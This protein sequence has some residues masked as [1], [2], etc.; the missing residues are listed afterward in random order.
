MRVYT[1]RMNPPY[2]M[3]GQ[4]V[5]KIIESKDPEYPKDSVVLT[6]SGWVKTGIVQTSGSL[7]GFGIKANQ[8]V[9][10]VPDLPPGLSQSVLLGVCGMPGCTAYFGF[11]EICQPKSGET[12]VVNGA[13][14]AVG[15]LVGQIAK[16]KGCHVIGFAGSDDKCQTLLKKYGFDKAYNYKKTS[17]QD[18]LKDG[19]PDGVDCFFDNVGGDDASTVINH[20]KPFGRIAVCGAIATYNDKERPRV[21]MTSHSFVFNQ[22]KM[23]GFL[24]TRWLDRWEEG[25]KQM[26][27]WVMQGKIQTEETVMEG[28][29]KMPDALIGLFTG[30]NKGK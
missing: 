30:S 29:E 28:F 25:I 1:K 11:L 22:L 7:G 5:A 17:V 4:N 27:T 12:V 6:K 24:V 8:L 20:M 15:S 26:A 16:I 3:I 19:A 23:E 14:G 18:A 9:D 21:P 2:T 10:K 13:A